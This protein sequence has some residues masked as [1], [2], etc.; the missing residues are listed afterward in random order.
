MVNNLMLKMAW[1]EIEFTSQ[2]IS[3]NTG[4]NEARNLFGDKNEKRNLYAS[5]WQLSYHFH[6]RHTYYCFTIFMSIIVKPSHF[7]ML[8]LIFS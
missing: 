8:N 1:H 5:G 2:C 6:F 3:H 7:R 4:R